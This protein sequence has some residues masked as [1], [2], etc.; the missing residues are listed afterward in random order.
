MT[1]T[2]LIE[3]L[4]ELNLPEAEVRF[5][6][7]LDEDTISEVVEDDGNVLLRW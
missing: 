1:V 6:C 7:V 2:E 3:K 5:G 4:E